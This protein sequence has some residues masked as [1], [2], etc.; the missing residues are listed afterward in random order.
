MTKPTLLAPAPSLIEPAHVFTTF[1][2]L[3]IDTAARADEPSRAA[4]SD[5][6]EEVETF[7]LPMR[8][9]GLVLESERRFRREGFLLTLSAHRPAEDEGPPRRLRM[10]R[11]LAAP[12]DYQAAKK[13]F[14]AH[15]GAPNKIDPRRIAA[16]YVSI[17]GGALAQSPEDAAERFA[18]GQGDLVDISIDVFLRSRRDPPTTFA[19]TYARWRTI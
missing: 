14:D 10:A 1:K 15:L 7:A 9:T 3:C 5:G 19:A 6:F 4:L 16:G 12:V 11:L 13:E 18:R 8:G 2:S 17:D